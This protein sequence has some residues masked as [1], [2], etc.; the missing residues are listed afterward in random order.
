MIIFEELAKIA[1][2]LAKETLALLAAL[3]RREWKAKG[4][5]PVTNLKNKALSTGQELAIFQLKKEDIPAFKK[6][7]REFGVLYHKPIFPPVF[8][9]KDG[10][11]LVDM[12]GLSGDARG[13][14]HILEKLGYP[15][16][17]RDDGKNAEARA[18]SEQNSPERGNGY[19]K[20]KQNRPSRENDAPAG[21]EESPGRG[22]APGRKSAIAD[23]RRFKKQADALK[24]GRAPGVSKTQAGPV[25]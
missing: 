8:L 9:S 2:H 1:G 11:A 17:E 13:I 15:V 24:A 10:E 20:S 12:V 4:A 22:E 21:Q 3:L 14:N 6:L 23:I 5:M 16:P 7:A 19:G 25:R 18:A